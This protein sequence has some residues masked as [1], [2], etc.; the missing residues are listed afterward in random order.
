MLLWQL[1]KN[2]GYNLENINYFD[3]IVIA[4]I[5]MLGLKGLFRG[6]IKEVFALIGLVAGVYI[7]SRNANFTG[8]L[9]SDN[10]IP[11]QGENTLMLVGF[12]ITLIAVWIVAYILG[13][14]ISKIF[15][16]SG[17]GL[18]DKLLGFIFGA[19]KVFFIL[20]IIVFAVSQIK[21]INTK[22]QE[23][24]KDSIMYPLLKQAGE[25]IIKIDPVEVQKDITTNIDN[26]VKTTQE[27]INS[28][29]DTNT[30]N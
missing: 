15:A 14:L 10:I 6:F 21:I 22:L 17:L 7:A 27:A 24:T 20:A 26:A 3:V 1:Y 8:H 29:K 18:F 30:S 23:T 28:I 11:I 4:L 12:V 9:I 16:V 25:I 5:V 13:A 19:G 2:T